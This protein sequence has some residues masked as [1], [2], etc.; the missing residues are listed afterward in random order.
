MLTVFSVVNNFL[1]PHIEGLIK[2]CECHK[3][4]QLWVF[5]SVLTELFTED[6]DIDFLYEFEQGLTPD[7]ELDHLLGFI[8]S[9]TEILNRRIDLVWVGGLRNPYFKEE[10]DQSK[11]LIYVKESEEVGALFFP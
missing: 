5:G 10:V 7:E 1:T 11:Q 6:S 8:E 2:L 4:S 3:L 9:A